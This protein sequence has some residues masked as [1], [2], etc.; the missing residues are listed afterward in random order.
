MWRFEDDEGRAWEVAVGRESWGAFFAIFV[1]LRR[2]GGI[3]Q[4]LLKV[5]S[6]VEATRTLDELDGRGWVRLLRE[7]RPKEME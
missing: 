1:P 7:S 3:R 6:Q 2:E 5:D 4:T